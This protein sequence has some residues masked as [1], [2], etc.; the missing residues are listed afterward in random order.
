[1]KKL[2]VAVCE[3]SDIYRERLAEF[4]IRKKGAQIQI[5]TFSCQERFL[6]RENMIHFDVILWGKGFER[7]CHAEPE[8]LL[9]YLSE[10]PEGEGKGRYIFKYQSAENIVRT[11]FSYYLE[12]EKP[13]HGVTR[14]EKEFIG[15]YSPTHSR[16]QTPFAMTLARL[17]GE[18][19]KVLYLN[20]GEWA[21][22]EPWMKEEYQRDLSD[23]LY[24]VSNRD[25]AIKGI[26]DS[27]VHS[28]NRLDYI[29]PMRDASLLA[30]TDEEDYQNLLTFLAE[31][32][33][34]QVIVLD[35]GV[36]IPGFFRF[37]EQC[38]SIYGILDKGVL[39]RWQ[40]QQFEESIMR[41][42]MEHLAEKIQEITFSAA[43]TKTMEEEP[44]LQQWLYGILGDRAQ[45]VRCMRYGTD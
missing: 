28:M 6:T 3:K 41:S 33:E 26:L 12:L 8:S 9:I 36:M 35:F 16:M 31:R 37:L 21:G 40:W 29:P 38:S 30:Q 42:G 23:L 7:I 15:V 25:N 13:D 14:Q 2:T 24:L 27:V 1:M 44:V 5:A 11:I 18:E 34:Y 32:T 17:I 20:F 39:A 4:V 19:K 22:F 45:A 10:T 43:E